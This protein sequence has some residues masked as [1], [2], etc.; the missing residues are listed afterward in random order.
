MAW[1]RQHKSRV[2]RLI[3]AVLP[4]FSVATVQP[5][6]GSA[7]LQPRLGSAVVQPRLSHVSAMQPRLGISR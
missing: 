3:S 5:H 7:A 1:I 6:L 2:H 4:C